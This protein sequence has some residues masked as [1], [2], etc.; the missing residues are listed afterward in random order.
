MVEIFS[1]SFKMLSVKLINGARMPSRGTEYSAGLDLASTEDYIL[2]PQ[3]TVKL[4]TGVA[5]E[6][7]KSTHG[8]IKMRSSV[9]MK[10]IVTND[11]IDNDYRGQIHLVLT[12]CSTKDFIIEK[13]VP[14]AQLVLYP[15]IYPKLVQVDFLNPTERGE[16]G[17]GSTNKPAPD[18]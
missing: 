4:P 3:T 12:N 17:F 16:K 8:E 1:L 11:I 2:K 18:R 15:D 6:F 7:P 13:N 9:S 10:G 14:I 5:I